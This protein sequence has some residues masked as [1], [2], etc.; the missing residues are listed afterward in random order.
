MGDDGLAQI[1]M[2]NPTYIDAVL[3]YHGPVQ[4]V[5]LEQCGVPRGIDAALA[6]QCLDW[7][8]RYQANQKEGNERHSQKGWDDQ[9]QTGQDKA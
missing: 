3:N 6:S 1:A 2:Q 5:F 4:P 9:A 8:A 7:V